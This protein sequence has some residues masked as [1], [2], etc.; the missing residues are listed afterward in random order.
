MPGSQPRRGSSVL[1]RKRFHEIP[2]WANDT[3]KARRRKRP[4]VQMKSRIVRIGDE[5]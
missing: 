3:G 4:L 1:R 2:A 5:S